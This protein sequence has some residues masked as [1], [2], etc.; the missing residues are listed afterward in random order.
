M[1]LT[2]NTNIPAVTV[3]RNL[4]AT[5]RRLE[6]SIGKLSSGLRIT[7]AADDAAG[8]AISEKMRAQARSLQQAQRNANDGISLAN[9]ADGALDQV[10][11]ML[12]RMRELAIQS[13]NGTNG[14]GERG[15]LD[16]EYQALTGEIER[17]ARSTSF[18]GVALLVGSTVVTF[19]VGAGT[20]ASVDRVSVTTLDVSTSAAGLALSSTGITTSAGSILAITA[21]D[22]AVDRVN[23]ARGRY[24]AVSNRMSSTIVGL[25]NLIQQTI[26]AESRIR[27]VD[28]A[29]ETAEFTRAQVLVQAGVSILGQANGINSTAMQL[30]R[31]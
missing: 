28:V 24:G 14:A 10:S 26:S 30:L 12:V 3:Q 16:S 8:L 1:A 20:V 5:S 11:A 9:V 21:L 15:A 4:S 19:Q 18:N 22:T 17:I 25:G 2:L 27:D 29:V 6:T 7:I 31:F 13:L 23:S